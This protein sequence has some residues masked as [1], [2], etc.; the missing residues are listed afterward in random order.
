[1]G[2]FMP[3]KNRRKERGRDKT[4]SNEQDTASNILVRYYEK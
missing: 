2:E 3:K 4:S 1:M